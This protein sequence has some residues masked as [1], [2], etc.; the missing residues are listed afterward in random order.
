MTKLTSPVLGARDCVADATQMESWNGLDPKVLS[1]A[2]LVESAMSGAASEKSEDL[3]STAVPS[4]ALTASA[5]SCNGTWGPQEFE[6]FALAEESGATP[7]MEDPS[8]DAARQVA[9]AAAVAAASAMSA[10]AVHT[11]QDRFVDLLP[12]LA[13]NEV[14]GSDREFDL[15]E[16]MLLPPTP[17]FP[18]EGVLWDGVIGGIGLE[19]VTQEEGSALSLAGH[20]ETGEWAWRIAPRPCLDLDD[21]VPLVVRLGGAPDGRASL[22]AASGLDGFS[23]FDEGS[24]MLDDIWK[25]DLPERPTMTIAELHSLF[26]RW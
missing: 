15:G 21:L 23:T 13:T 9:V 20:A 17:S 26:N 19:E 18:L 5:G 7:I 8:V 24:N 2:A 10:G 6:A 25:C 3:C 11:L 16:H 12:G 22:E 1:S 4:P 14:S